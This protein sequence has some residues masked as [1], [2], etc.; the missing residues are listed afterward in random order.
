MP[1]KVHNGKI[2]KINVCTLETQMSKYKGDFK[3]KGNPK[4][5]IKTP[6]RTKLKKSSFLENTVEHMGGQT[7]AITWILNAYFS[8]CNVW[9]WADIRY[10]II[11]YV[12]SLLPVHLLVYLAYY[13]KC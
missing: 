13:I 12:A 7:K 8:L 2:K 10:T 11:L 4:N 1:N 5:R 6:V 9:I 3:S